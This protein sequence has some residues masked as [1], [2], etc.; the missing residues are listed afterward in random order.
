MSLETIPYVHMKS[1]GVRS[2][3][4]VNDIPVA[5]AFGQESKSFSA[6]IRQYLVQGQNTVAVAAGINGEKIAEGQFRASL[7]WFHEGED[8]DFGGGVP[9][10]DFQPAF[11]ENVPLPIVE[12]GSFQSDYGGNWAWTRAQPIDPNT[13]RANL[14]QFTAWA[15]RQFAER[16]VS[17][18]LPLFEP[19]FQDFSAA[20]PVTTL[21]GLRSGFERRMNRVGAEWEPVPFD[22]ARAVYL[23]I[24][25]GRMVELLDNEGLPLIRTQ[26]DDP[27]DPFADPN[28][29]ELPLR[30]GLLDGSVQVLN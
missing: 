18:L 24:A 20:Y 1:H 28:Y 27:I 23:P 21:E 7:G 6:P 26:T 12:Q 19:V 11:P 2:E 16:N 15:A 8:V 17:A 5:R 4:R 25:N 3:V 22:P 29:K 30:I 14:D 13:A 9:I 10:A